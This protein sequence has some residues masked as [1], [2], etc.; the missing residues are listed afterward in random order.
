LTDYFSEIQTCE[1]K[2]MTEYP[3]DSIGHPDFIFS[4]EDC[5]ILSEPQLNYLISSYN[6]VTKSFT[7][8]LS[9]G[10]GHDELLDIQQINIYRNDSSCF[11]KSTYSKEIFVYSFNDPLPLMREEIPGNNASFFFDNNKIVCSQYGE[12]RFA[13]YD[14]QNNSTVEFGDSIVIENCTPDLV[15]Y[16]LQGLCTG[17][18]ELKRIVWASIYGDIFEIYDYGNP[19]SIKTIISV[20]GVFPVIDALQKQ[21]VLSPESK[22]GI[23]S[24]AATNKYIYMLYNESKIKDFSDKKDDVLLC[25]KILVYDWDGIPQKILKTNKFIRSVSYN[26]KHKKIFCLGY[27]DTGNGKIFYIDDLL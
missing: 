25:N 19:D 2:E 13:L 4:H 8:F 6:M 12:K 10:A 11:V 7:R 16:V 21:P 1:L 22:L 9:K 15:S 18:T 20:K 5:I 3:V 14:R 27:D 23:V 26:K 24:I 17:N